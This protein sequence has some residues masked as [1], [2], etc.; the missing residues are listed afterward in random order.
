MASEVPSEWQ[1]KILHGNIEIN[2]FELAGTD[3]LPEQYE[4]PSGFCLLLRLDSEQE[5]HRLFEAL[6]IDGNVV[7]SPQQTFWSPCYAIVTD[8]FGVP[9]KLNCVA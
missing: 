9:W 5:V 8:Q 1:D 4:K 3:T 2:N 7:L 6:A